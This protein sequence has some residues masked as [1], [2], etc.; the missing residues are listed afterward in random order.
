MSQRKIKRPIAQNPS[1][2]NYQREQ[3]E[4]Q[5]IGFIVGLVKFL[6]REDQTCKNEPDKQ[7]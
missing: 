2:Q 7:D 6:K 4:E 5:P 3:D 1:I